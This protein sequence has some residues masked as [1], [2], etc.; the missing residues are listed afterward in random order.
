MKCFLNLRYKQHKTDYERIPETRP[1]PVP[2]RVNG[3]KCKTYHYVPKNGT[4][5][6][7]CQC[8]HFADDH[9]EV[10]PYKCSKGCACKKFISS[11]TCGCGQPSYAHKVSAFSCLTQETSKWIDQSRLLSISIGLVLTCNGGS[12][13]GM[14]LKTDWF[15]PHYPQL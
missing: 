3:C 9:S 15:F 6:I 7:R 14:Q 11:Y 5:P 10:V 13:R 4:Q 1:I 8:K 2:C 12:C